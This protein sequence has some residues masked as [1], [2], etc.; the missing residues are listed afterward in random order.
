MKIRNQLLR[1]APLAAL[2][3]P[4]GDALAAV[5][6]DVTTALSDAKTDSMAVAGL[7]LVVIIAVAAFKYMRKGV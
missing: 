6:A 3:A 1:Y 7:A 4:F 2:A 5:P